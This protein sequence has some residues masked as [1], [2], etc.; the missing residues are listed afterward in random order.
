MILLPKTYFIL[1][2]GIILILFLITGLKK[3][4][5]NYFLFASKLNFSILILG[6]IIIGYFF[7]KDYQLFCIP[8]TWA[9][10]VLFLYSIYL[11]AN[12]IFKKII[13]ELANQLILGIGLFISFYIIGFGSAEYLIWSSV[14]LIAIVPIYFLTRYLNKKFNTSFFDFL[15][16]YGVT[17]L[18]P[19][20]II[21][22]T[23]WQVLDK[24]PFYKLSLIV[25]PVLIFLFGIFLTFRMEKIIE[26]IDN[27]ENKVATLELITENKIDNYLTEL[28][29]GA[30]WK[31]HTKIC[32]YDGW[33]PPFHDPVL[34]FAQLFLYNG[35]QFNY[36][37]SMS[38]RVYL[39]E[40][41]FPENS[42][43]FDSKCAKNERL[44][45]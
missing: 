23:I 9:K 45:K 30:H 24:R 10:I 19:Y 26:S 27:S 41:I 31:Y 2:Q 7:N 36:E 8:V 25:L 33:R 4:R 16:L 11:I 18:L 44:I 14:H 40:K 6:A 1:V 38:N 12:W 15:N 20:I 43:T 28:I 39:Y 5:K 29:L 42:R 34:G 17:I 3:R 37:L 35:K 32:L 21:A 22:W 13:G